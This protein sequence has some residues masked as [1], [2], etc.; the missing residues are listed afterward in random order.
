MAP[1]GNSNFPPKTSKLSLDFILVILAIW[2]IFWREILTVWK[3]KFWQF[4]KKNFDSLKMKILTVWKE[5]FWQFGNENFDSLEREIWNFVWRENLNYR[6]S[7][8][9]F[10]I[11]RIAIMI[12][13]KKKWRVDFHNS[14]LHMFPL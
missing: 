10:E 13:F 11:S 5:K 3:A 12:F 1:N 9:F 14:A 4:G 2:K 6:W 8:R 7:L